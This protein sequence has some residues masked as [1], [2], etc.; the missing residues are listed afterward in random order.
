MPNLTLA[1]LQGMLGSARGAAPK[2]PPD[3]TI[4]RDLTEEDSV[5]LLSPPPAGSTAP[6]LKRVR[7]QHHHLARLIASGAK[8]VEAGAISGF[9]SSRVSILRRD[10]AFA[11][12]VEYYRSQAEQKFLDVHE[13]LASVGMAVVEEI[14]ERLEEDPAQFSPK[15]LVLIGE[16]TLDRS[17]APPKS[18]MGGASGA[19]PQI[20]ISFHGGAP[21]LSQEPAAPVILDFIEGES[22][23]PG[24]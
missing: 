4:L 10:P 20:S 9:S 19:L 18:K 7:T 8:D 21:L 1:D 24:L 3:F 5:E 6:L 11:E 14:H 13:R 23:E 16:F 22:E 15:E 2:A 12:L 17:S